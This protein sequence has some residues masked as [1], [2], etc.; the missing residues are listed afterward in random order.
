MP[1]KYTQKFAAFSMCIMVMPVATAELNAPPE[2]PPSANAI[3]I[4]AEPM[5]RARWCP[6]R[7]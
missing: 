2:M 5:A 7:R 4:K 3:I 6:N 1:I